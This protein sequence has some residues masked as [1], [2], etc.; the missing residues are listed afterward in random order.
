[1]RVALV[2]LQDNEATVEKLDKSTIPEQ[3]KTGTAQQFF[4]W[5]A[6]RIVALAEQCHL[7]D[8][9]DSWKLGVTWSFPFAY[10]PNLAAIEWSLIMAGKTL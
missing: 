3:V 7:D 2:R 10:V 9:E 5:I 8:G 4:R 1:M 6:Q